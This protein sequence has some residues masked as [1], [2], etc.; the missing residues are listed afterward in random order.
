MLTAYHSYQASKGSAYFA[1]QETKDAQLTIKV[2]GLVKKLDQRIANRNGY[3]LEE[4]QAVDKMII[5]LE[6]E[7]DLT[8]VSMDEQRWEMELIFFGC[9]FR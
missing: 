1:N 6:K 7:R 2:E 9:I 8:Q 5:E 3:L 4:E